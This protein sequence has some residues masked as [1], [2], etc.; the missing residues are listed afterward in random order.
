MT[1]NQRN[2]GSSRKE[3]TIITP[4]KLQIHVILF[5]F[6]TP[7]QSPGIL[8]DIRQGLIPSDYAVLNTDILKNIFRNQ[9]S[10]SYF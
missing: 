9:N 5:F 4:R 3:R 6:A 10:I 2:L 1:V 7:L 8:S